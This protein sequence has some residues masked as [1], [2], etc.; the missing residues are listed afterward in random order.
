MTDNFINNARG[1]VE[2]MERLLSRAEEIKTLHCNFTHG[3]RAT[4]TLDVD[5]STIFCR[6]LNATELADTLQNYLRGENL[7]LLNCLRENIENLTVMLDEETN[8]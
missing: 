8:R 4:L 2:Q 5:N 6:E 3:K 7:R 1:C